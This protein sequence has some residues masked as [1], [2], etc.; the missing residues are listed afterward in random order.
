METHDS[1]KRRGS[2]GQSPQEFF[3]IRAL[4]TVGKRRKHLLSICCF[5]FSL[6]RTSNRSPAMCHSTFL[7]RIRLGNRKFNYPMD[8]L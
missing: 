5:D 1:Y 8:F 2:W 3:P 6:R 4:Q 7:L